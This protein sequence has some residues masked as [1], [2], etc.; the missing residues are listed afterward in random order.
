MTPYYQDAFATIYHGDCREI[1]P[2]MPKVDLVVTSPPYDDLRTYGEAFEWDFEETAVKLCPLLCGGCVICWNVADAT[3]NGSETGTSFRQALRFKELGLNLHDTMIYEKA[4]FSNPIHNRY[5]QIFEYIFVLSLGK[6]KT[7]NP[8]KD[9]RNAYGAPFGKNTFRKADGSMGERPV[10]NIQEFGMRTNIWRMKT[11]GQ[12]N[13][14][15]SNPH[16][17]QMPEGLATDLIRSW[18]NERDLVLDPFAGSGTTL[19]AAKQLGRKAI[20]I[21]LEEKYCEI[22]AKRLQQEYLPLNAEPAAQTKDQEL[23]NV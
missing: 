17:A 18:S 14:C 13:I 22:A 19:V 8:I 4:N 21:E 16:P 1:L 12:E 10:N 7:F 3:V 5:H 23:F 2:M 9:K 20:G 11:A 6:P 15:Q